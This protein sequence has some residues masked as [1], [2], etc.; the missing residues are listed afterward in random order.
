MVILTAA[1]AAFLLTRP[2]DTDVVIEPEQVE[3]TTGRLSTDLDL[4]G[5]AAAERSVALG[6][7]VAGVVALVVVEEGDLVSM[8]DAL[9]T[10]A[11]R[12]AQRQV[13]TAQV[14]LRQAQLRL[15]ELLANPEESAV[16]SAN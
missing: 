16:A 7:E 1:V 3:A 15:D 14:Q 6:S 10:L 11:D 13:E 8:G 4:S 9:A 12:D 5:S 2:E